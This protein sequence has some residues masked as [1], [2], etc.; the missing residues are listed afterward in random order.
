MSLQ[1]RPT[2][3][4]A[5]EE[6]V[7]SEGTGLAPAFAL[8]Q[9]LFFWISQ[10]LERRDRQLGEGL[11]PL[12]LRVAEWR[13]LASLYSRQRLSMTE[14]AD[15][16]NIER[17]TLSRTVDRMVRAGWINRLTDTSDARVT[18]LS[19]TANGERLFARVWPAVRAVNEAATTGIPEPAVEMARWA[20]RQMCRNFDSLVGRGQRAI[21]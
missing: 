2:A 16:T 18:R 21:A 6:P 17:T 1:A 20:M 3:H 11:K 19:L 12:G 4:S 13:A 5:Q 14:L 15:L 8:E 7:S 10:L 9:H